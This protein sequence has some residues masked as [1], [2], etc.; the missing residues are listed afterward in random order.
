MFGRLEVLVPSEKEDFQQ[1]KGSGGGGKG[2]ANFGLLKSVREEQWK[3]IF[4]LGRGK[5]SGG[6][7]LGGGAGR[8]R[9]HG[10]TRAKK[11]FK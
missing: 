2:T 9:S 4:L 6:G 3:N 8:R 5:K 10:E 11:F 7:S 1:E